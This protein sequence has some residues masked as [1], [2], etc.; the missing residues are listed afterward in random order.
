[1]DERRQGNGPT[2]IDGVSVYEVGRRTGVYDI[3]S[4][5]PDD[6]TVM[7]IDWAFSDAHIRLTDT[8]PD[9]I[10]ANP[11]MRFRDHFGAP[12]LP[13]I[14]ALIHTLPSSFLLNK[15]KEII[16]YPVLE[17]EGIA[18]GDPVKVE[19]GGDEDDFEFRVTDI[20]EDEEYA[21]RFTKFMDIVVGKDGNIVVTMRAVRKVKPTVKSILFKTAENGGKFPVMAQVFKRIAEEIKAEFDF[22][23]DL[24]AEEVDDEDYHEDPDADGNK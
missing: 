14:S 22:G 7:N 8:N 23:E 9:R 16:K 21:G 19:L 24:S 10:Q 5:E 4:D 12:R 1:M 3:P 13:M 2:I 15:G 20:T 17:R 11:T 18:Y 6:T